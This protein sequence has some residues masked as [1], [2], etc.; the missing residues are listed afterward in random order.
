VE[1]A[2]GILAGLFQVLGTTINLEPLKVSIITLA[3]CYLHNFLI[4][5]NEERYL[6]FSGE[7]VDR[8]TIVCMYCGVGKNKA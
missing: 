4:Q 3:C 8:C 2:F 1:N 5:E 6:A 7:A